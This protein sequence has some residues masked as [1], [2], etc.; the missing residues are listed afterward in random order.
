VVLV[1]GASFPRWDQAGIAGPRVVR[2]GSSVELTLAD[3]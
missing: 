3:I 2:D 1:A